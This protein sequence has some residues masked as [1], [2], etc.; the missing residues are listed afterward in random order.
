MRDLVVHQ[1]NYYLAQPC[2]IL[3]LE[4]AFGHPQSY[5]SEV[6]LAKYYYI[7][8]DGHSMGRYAEVT[9]DAEGS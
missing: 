1:R 4:K 6:G 3:A 2:F 7:W 8:N 5:W 9:K